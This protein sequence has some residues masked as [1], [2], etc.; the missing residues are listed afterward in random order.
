MF[1]CPQH[2]LTGFIFRSHPFYFANSIA[3]AFDNSRTTKRAG[4]SKSDDIA[5][6]KLIKRM[7]C[8]SAS[9]S[10]AYPT[11]LIIVWRKEVLFK[12]K[13]GHGPEPGT[14]KKGATQSPPN[15]SDDEADS[16][17][18]NDNENKHPTVIDLNT[19]RTRAN[20]IPVCYLYKTS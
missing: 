18:A 2:F 19:P 10:T 14:Q 7:F 17:T 8:S 1:S 12:Y 16:D 13:A 11:V 3:A 5:I 4:Q 15:S 9:D 20:K 6:N